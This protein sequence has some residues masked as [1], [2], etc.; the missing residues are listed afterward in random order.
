VRAAYYSAVKEGD[1]ETVV[2]WAGEVVDLIKSVESA[3]ALVETI[4]SEAEALLRSAGRLV[5]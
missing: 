5:R 4:S 2:V 1:F 3:A